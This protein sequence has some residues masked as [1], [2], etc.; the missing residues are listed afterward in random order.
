M[1]EEFHVPGLIR[2]EPAAMRVVEAIEAHSGPPDAL[3]LAVVSGNGRNGEAGLAGDLAA[4]A[5]QGSV[6]LIATD[7]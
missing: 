6:G 7:L 1:T 2:T 5:P 4:S 3:R